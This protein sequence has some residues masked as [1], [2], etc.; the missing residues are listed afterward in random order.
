VYLPA[1]PS[2]TVPGTPAEIGEWGELSSTP[3]VPTHV[4]VLGSQKVLYWFGQLW[5]APTYVLDPVTGTSTTAGAAQNDIFCSGHTTLADGRVISIGGHTGL[6]DGIPDTYIHD[7]YAGTA[8]RVADMAQARWYPTATTLRDGRILATAGHIAGGVQATIPEIYSVAT[9]TWT[10]LTGAALQLPL[11]PFMFLL[12]NGKLFQAGAEGGGAATRTLD[13]TA[14]SWATVGNTVA[15]HGSAA[16]YVPG[17]VLR[18]GGRNVANT[19]TVANAEVIDMTEATPAWRSVAPM[20]FPRQKHNLVLLPDGSALAVGGRTNN[21]IPLQSQLTA[22]RF[23]PETET[24]STMA[25]MAEPRMYHSTA[26][27]LPDG[28]VMSAGGN[29]Y[30]SYQIYSPPYLF[31]GPRPTIASVSPNWFYEVWFTME[32][33]DAAS[34]ASVVLMRP[35]STTHGFDE[36]QRLVPIAFEQLEWNVL[37]IW[38]PLTR[39]VAP[40]GEYLFFLVNDQGVPSLGT[41][42]RLDGPE[43]CG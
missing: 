36:N 30:P 32:T 31:K 15:T 7:P 28:R 13:L 4:T 22:E 29:L 16:M 33:Q 8:T 5:P 41:T 2:C 19:V 25:C 35:A 11:Y 3:A 34:I 23:D 42:I 27:L 14:Q 26:A 9:N 17:K 10:P 38:T 1:V 21:D 43:G 24:W 20:A 12:P 37:K 39:D 40:P 6:F 18:S